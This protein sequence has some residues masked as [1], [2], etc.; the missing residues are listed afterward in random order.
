MSNMAGSIT[1][2]NDAKNEEVKKATTRQRRKSRDLEQDV[3]GM[4]IKDKEKLK[5]I[6][7]EIDTDGSGELDVS[8]LRAALEKCKPGERIT[9]TQVRA[10]RAACVPHL[11]LVLLHHAPRPAGAE[12]PLLQSC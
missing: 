3:F 12:L 2:S 4:H 7:D 8:E 11:I 9:D 6:F 1:A 10:Q 5:K